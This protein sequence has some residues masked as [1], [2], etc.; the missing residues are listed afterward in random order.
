MDRRIFGSLLLG[1]TMLFGKA[2]AV[3]NKGDTESSQQLDQGSQRD[4]LFWLSDDDRRTA[5]ASALS[6]LGKLDDMIYSKFEE[7]RIAKFYED[8]S[9]SVKTRYQPKEFF[10]LIS[11][12]R[13]DF[14]ERKDKA[15]QGTEGGF[16]L[17][18]NFPDSKYAIITFDSLFTLKDQIYTEQIIVDRRDSLDWRFVDYYLDV[19]PFY[20]Y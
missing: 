19:N 9:A 4:Y 1:G 16:K 15:F 12:Y 11:K 14:G 5:S 17:L 10:E 3:S 18:P 8:S 7:P 13:K 2:H 6:L 20:K